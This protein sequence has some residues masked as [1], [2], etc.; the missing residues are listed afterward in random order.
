LRLIACQKSIFFHLANVCKTNFAGFLP[1]GFFR[2]AKTSFAGTV[3]SM[4][5][6]VFSTNWQ[7]LANPDYKLFR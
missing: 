6:T 1:G 4:E 3:F 7:K 2:P 5:K